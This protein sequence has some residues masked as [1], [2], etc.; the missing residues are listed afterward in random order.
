MFWG[1]CSDGTGSGGVRSWTVRAERRIRSFATVG[2]KA[3]LAGGER[4]ERTSAA[5]GPPAS[6]TIAMEAAA[7]GGGGE[8]G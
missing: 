4:G 3:A 5:T 8:C 2:G 1:S 6:R 7:A